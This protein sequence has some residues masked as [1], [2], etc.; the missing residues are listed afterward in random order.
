MDAWVNR[1]AEIRQV[2]VEKRKGKITRPMNSFML[3]RSAYADRTKVWCLQNN[4]QVVS[5]V[6]GESWPMEPKEIRDLYTEY[7]RIERDNHQKAHPG[8]KFSPSKA[9]AASRKRRETSEEDEEELSDLDNLDSEWRPA[10]AKS[11]RSSGVKRTT[12][13]TTWQ[14]GNAMY[15]SPERTMTSNPIQQQSTYHY[16]NPGKPL[17]IPMLNDDLY[18]QYYQTS[19]RANIGHPYTEDVFVRRANHAGVSYGTATPLIG[20][21]GGNHSEL[22][23]EHPTSSTPVQPAEPQVDP[24]LLAQDGNDFGGLPTPSKNEHDFGVFDHPD[25]FAIGAEPSEY[26]DDPTL[27]HGLDTWHY[28]GNTSPSAVVTDFDRWLGHTSDEVT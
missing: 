15:S 21:P 8:Y 24:F 19:V 25:L 26:Q 3:Y 7:A 1:S 10:R 22:L 11:L 13:D 6:S 4:H 20:L 28:G 18:G 12:P 9:G 14:T 27:T 5:S 2:E 16:N 17:P 23:D